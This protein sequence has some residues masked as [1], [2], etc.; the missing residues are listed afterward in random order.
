M[1][2]P[3]VSTVNHC[4]VS[5]FVK[6]GTVKARKC[7][8][9][10]IHVPCLDPVDFQKIVSGLQGVCVDKIRWST[11]WLLVVSNFGNLVHAMKK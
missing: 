2:V 8:V 9:K 10:R 1:R 5:P 6:L 3:I 11:L 4:D 7:W